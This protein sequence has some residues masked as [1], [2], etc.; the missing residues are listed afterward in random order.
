MAFSGCSWGFWPL[1]ASPDVPGQFLR[2]CKFQ[3]NADGQVGDKLGSPEGARR[4]RTPRPSFSGFKLVLLWFGTGG[5]RL[6]GPQGRIISLDFVICPRNRIYRFWACLVWPSWACFG[7]FLGH[8]GPVLGCL[9][10]VLGCLGVSCRCHS[11]FWS[12]KKE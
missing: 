2:S 6:E 5:G 10:P 1:L 4:F 8:L 7:P 12:D 3:K 11:G 9:A